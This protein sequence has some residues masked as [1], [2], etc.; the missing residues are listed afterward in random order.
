MK[1]IL[2][3]LLIGGSTLFSTQV[4]LIDGTIIKG[5]IIST[6]DEELQIKVSYSED[7]L[8][9]NRNQVLDIKF[10]E[11]LNAPPVPQSQPYVALSSQTSSVDL[12]HAAIRIELAGEKL[13]NFKENY[14]T[15]FF[16]STI[17]FFFMFVAQEEGLAL[18]GFCTS[19]VG[20]AIQLMAFTKAGAA[21]EE[22]KVAAQEMKRINN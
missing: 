14:Y 1:K 22:L 4:I 15:G 13:I 20:S 7:L 6:S 16:I 10:D 8:K 18:A 3:A 17:G 9:I 21:G 2:L 19:V 5:E 11:S 12:S